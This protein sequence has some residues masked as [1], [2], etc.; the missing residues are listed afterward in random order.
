MAN[1]YFPE[2]DEDN[3]SFDAEGTPTAGNKKAGK[4][5]DSA[6]PEWAQIQADIDESAP[7][8]APR[9][10]VRQQPSRPTRNQP[11]PP[12]T[13]VQGVPVPQ[14]PVQPQVP[15][16]VPA[17][18]PPVAA[19]QP[20]PT[21]TPAPQ[22]TPVQAPPVQPPI[23]TKTPVQTQKTE[24]PVQESYREPDV[25]KRSKP[26]EFA[27]P[28]PVG[29]P[30]SEDRLISE[31]A[32][33][34]PEPKTSK[35]GKGKKKSAAARAGGRWKLLLIRYTVWGVMG[36][37]VL[38]GIMRIINPVPISVASIT[39]QV[40]SALGRNGFPMEVGEQ[41]A[42]RFAS[43][44]LNFNSATR[45]EREANLN[46]YLAP[47]VD[48]T[49]TFSSSEDPAYV[50]KVVDG[51]YLAGMPTLVDETHVTFTFAALVAGP[52][53][54]KK[55]EG[56][57]IIQPQWVYLAVPMFADAEGK[58]AVIGAPALVPQP[59]L[60]GK[61][62]FLPFEEDKEASEQALESVEGYF[63]EWAA[64]TEANPV[65]NQYLRKNSTHDARVG[66]AGTVTLASK[67]TLIVE[68]LPKNSKATERN[69]RVTVEWLAPG[70]VKMKQTY[71]L[72]LEF[73]DSHWYIIDLKGGSFY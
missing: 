70:G 43:T 45:S 4:N 26:Q 14:P 71:S 3:S 40:S 20:A 67:V 52:N 17:P 21:P 5:K 2:D 7:A 61:A 48:P 1:P 34:E 19:P 53:V 36:L 25:V 24:P 58:V 8:A 32:A 41:T 57:E 44:Y 35:F 63:Q 16:A 73:V 59:P 33:W 18:Q 60:A 64:A 51:P 29:F 12:P 72:I 6:L 22:P 65:S 42:T 62:E 9:P 50:Q 27:T 31:P 47:G 37:V 49:F 55:D 10:P 69:A 13:P 68:A 66:L 56:G 54:G 15:V 30:G 46:S 28:I 39:Q 23:E 11:T 38:L